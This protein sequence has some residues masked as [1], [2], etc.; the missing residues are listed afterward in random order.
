MLKDAKYLAG[1]IAPLSALAAVCFGG[2]WSYSTV[3]ISFVLVPLLEWR[4][5]GS[6][7]NFTPEEAQKR[8]SNRFFDWVLYLNIPLYFTILWLYFS[9]VKSGGHALYE[10]IGMTYSVGIVVSTIGI[11]VAH[12]LG[13]R[14]NKV[15]QFLSKMLLMTALYMHF[16]IEHNRGHHKNVAT[17]LDPATSRLGEP[18]YAF[19]VRSTWQSYFHAWH[20][21]NRRLRRKGLSPFSLQNEM[22]WYHLIQAG[23]LVAI[24]YWF[25][26]TMIGYAIAIAVIGFL[27]LESVNYIEHYGLQRKKLPNG[28]YEKV[29]PIHSWNSNH[30]MGRILLYELTRHSDHHYKAS[31]KYQI[32]RHFDESPQL[33]HGYPGSILMAL[34]PPLW[35]KH[36]NDRVRQLN[37]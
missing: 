27:L 15:E 29:R 7:Q 31:R 3:V 5:P 37:A 2:V 19:W 28:K 13:H 33:P 18:I 17:E 21:E 11:N 34:V 1:Y 32:L 4:H 9:A 26:W 12:E 8:L 22:I 16:F 30:E 14:A 36:M 25:G 10:I 23:Y 6:T 35:F 20:L 24:G